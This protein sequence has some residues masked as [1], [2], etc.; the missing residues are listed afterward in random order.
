MKIGNRLK[1]LRKVRRMTLKVASQQSGLSVSFLSDMERG[2]TNPSLNTLFALSEVYNI[3]LR[4]ML[5]GV[6]K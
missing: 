1:D 4:D 5:N 3:K 2:R 6:A